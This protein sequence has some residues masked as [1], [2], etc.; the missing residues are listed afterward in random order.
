MGKLMVPFGIPELLIYAVP[1]TAGIVGGRY[2][3]RLAN[4]CLMIGVFQLGLM[5]LVVTSTSKVSVRPLVPYTIVALVPAIAGIV[6]GRYLGR[7]ANFCLIIA[8]FYIGGVLLAFHG[9]G[10]FRPVSFLQ[11]IFVSAG[12]LLP[13]LVFAL[14]ARMAAG[15]RALVA[16]PATHQ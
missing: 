13:P 14:V 12:S 15:R 9:T 2:L 4:F 6:G 3:S 10:E 16:E 1:A 8:V 5:I 7:H 11:G